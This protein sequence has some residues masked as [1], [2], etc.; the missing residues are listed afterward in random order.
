MRQQHTDGHPPATHSCFGELGLLYS[1]PRAA[2]VRAVSQSRLWV[3]DRGVLN[4]IKRQHAEAVRAERLQVLAK[5]PLLER[6]TSHH[7]ALLADA[8]QLVGAGPPDRSRKR[9][10]WSQRCH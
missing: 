1:A 6:V 9:P 3:M 2:T 5:L 8:L 7:R 10:E 4:A